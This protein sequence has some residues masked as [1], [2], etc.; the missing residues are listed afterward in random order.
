MVRLL[1]FVYRARVEDFATLRR[2]GESEELP[3]LDVIETS[4]PVINAYLNPPPDLFL[5]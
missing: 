3:K 5:E 2:S 1:T 4:Q